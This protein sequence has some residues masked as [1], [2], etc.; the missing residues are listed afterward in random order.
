MTTNPRFNFMEKKTAQQQLWPLLPE[1]MRPVIQLIFRRIKKRD[2]ENLSYDLIAYIRFGIYRQFE[3][4]FMGLLFDGMVNII[5][6]S[7]VSDENKLE[8]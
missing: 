2:Q 3:D 8:Q 7:T 1:D 6:A 5:D 4:A